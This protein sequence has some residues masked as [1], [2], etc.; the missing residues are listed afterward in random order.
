L[1]R[2]YQKTRSQES[3]Y[4]Y[5]AYRN[6]LT[7]ILRKAE[8]IHYLDKLEYVKDN[9][10]KTWKILKSLISPSSRKETFDEIV[11]NDKIIRDPKQI[12]DKFNIFFASVGPNLAAKIPKSLDNFESYLK[13]KTASTIFLKPTDEPEIQAIIL[14]LKNSTTKGHDGIMINTIKEC[15]DQLATPLCV[16]FNKSIHEGIVPDDLKIANIIPVFKSEDKIIVSNYRPISVLP[17]FS[18]ILERLIYNRLM[19]FIEQHNIISDSQYG[20][21]KKISTSV[22]LLDLVDKVSNSIETGEYTLGIFLD[23]AKA[24]D[25][26]NHKILLTK[27]YSYGIR[28]IAYN[29]LKNY[30]TNRYQY[31]HLN[32][33]SSDKLPIVCGVPQ[34]SILG[35]LLFLLYINDL[36]SVSTVLTLIMFADDTNMFISGRNLLDLTNTAN[37]ELGKISSWFS[38]NLLSLNIKKTNYI[39]FGNKKT[40]RY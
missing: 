19:D 26:V 38:T 27:L 21:R 9:L 33:I 29:W 36:N 20:F 3:L 7:T 28:G 23:I 25:T 18:K 14:S 40:I 24:F 6:K 17:A 30:L 2:K 4:A 32:D 11:H 39:L 37:I 1:Y 15:N 16:L 10:A 31:V 12:A 8:K 22:A 35:P 34:G 13:S 5:K